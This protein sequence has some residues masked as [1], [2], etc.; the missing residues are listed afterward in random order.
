MKVLMMGAACVTLALGFAASV[1]AQGGKAAHYHWKATVSL[2]SGDPYN[3]GDPPYP[4]Y[5]IDVE[6]QSLHGI[7]LDG[8]SRFV[9]NIV[10]DLGALRPDGSGRI[11][12]PNRKGVARYFDFEPGTGPRKFRVRHEDRECVFLWTP[13]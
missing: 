10:L 11:T 2:D 3:C 8:E 6:G 5:T 1:A 9:R 7:S 13:S 4:T 12:A